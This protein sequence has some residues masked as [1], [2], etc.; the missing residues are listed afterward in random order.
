MDTDEKLICPANFVAACWQCQPPRFNAFWSLDCE[1]WSF[2]ALRL[3]GSESVSIC[4]HPW[5][6]FFLP[7]EIDLDHALVILHFVHAAFA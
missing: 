3:T 1:V 2:H 4:V 6:S 7:T 5:L